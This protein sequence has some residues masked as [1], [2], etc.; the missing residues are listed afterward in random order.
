MT[1]SKE[2]GKHDKSSGTGRSGTTRSMILFARLDP[3]LGLVAFL[4][5]WG[6]LGCLLK[7]C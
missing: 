7:G 5:A 3:L 6:L 4:A 1:A 2:T